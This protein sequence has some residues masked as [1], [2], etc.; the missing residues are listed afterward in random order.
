MILSVIYRFRKDIIN[1][2]TDRQMEGWTD[3]QTDKQT[4][5]WSDGQTDPLIEI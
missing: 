2:P 4:D 3:R 1:G 5:R